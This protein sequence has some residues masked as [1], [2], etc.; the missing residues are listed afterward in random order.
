MDISSLSDLFLALELMNAEAIAFLHHFCY[1]E[2]LLLVG[3][4]TFLGYEH[5]A[6]HPSYFLGQSVLDHVFGI[7]GVVVYAVHGAQLVIPLG[8][9]AFQVHVGESQRPH[10]LVHS[11][12]FSPVLYGLQQQSRYFCVIDEVNPSESDGL[13]IPLLVGL[14]VDDGA[15][16][17]HYL[18]VA[19]CQEP[20]CF[21]EAESRVLLLV[22]C[23]Q[24][25]LQE[26]GYGIGVVLVQFVIETHEFLHLLFA[27][28]S[29]YDNIFCRHVAICKLYLT[30][31]VKKWWIMAVMGRF[32]FITFVLLKES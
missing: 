17:S 31:L 15:Y 14:V 13:L 16:A 4:M 7:V 18:P 2:G 1:A 32:L 24:G 20:F 8:E 25:V 5:L 12:F 10:H 27:G 11:P 6:L 22:E 9:H 19:S 29:A 23:V 21:T 28:D 3:F 26:V 30:K